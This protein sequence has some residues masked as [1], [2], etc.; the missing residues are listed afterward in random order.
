MSYTVKYE[1]HNPKTQHMQ[2]QQAHKEVA[3]THKLRMAAQK[4]CTAISMKTLQAHLISKIKL[5]KHHRW[6]QMLYL[7]IPTLFPSPYITTPHDQQP[8][9]KH[10]KQTTRVPQDSTTPPTA[11]RRISDHMLMVTPPNLTTSDPLAATTHTWHVILNHAPIQRLAHIA[12]HDVITGI[13]PTTINTTTPITCSACADGRGTQQTHPR[14][15]HDHHRP[16][17]IISSDTVGPIQPPSQLAHRHIRA[18]FDAAISIAIRY[19]AELTHLIQTTIQ[20]MAAQ[21]NRTPRR[22]HL[23]NAR[24]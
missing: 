9:H 24:E 2:W 10:E 14:T 13:T 17:E 8:T 12:R 23:D 1:Q 15:T 11:N 3:G 21:N 18:V 6:R 19:R 7:I 5:H 20:Q 22:F 4:V 16:T